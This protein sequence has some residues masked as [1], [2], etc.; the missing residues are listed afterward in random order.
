MIVAL[1]LYRSRSRH[2]AAR[3]VGGRTPGALAGPMAPLRLVNRPEPNPPQSGWARLRPRL[4]GICGSDLATLSGQSSLYLSPLVSTPFVPGHEVVGELLDDAGDVPAGTRVVLDPVLSCG[5]RGLSPCP[6]CAAGETSRCDHITVGDLAPGLQTGYC[7]DTGGGWAHTMLAHRDQVQPVP[8]AL[9][10]EQA[11]LAEPLA[12]AIHAARRARLSG[13]DHVL[14]VGAGTVGLL[15]LVALRALTAAT[16]ITVVAKHPRQRD[17][18][19]EL[20]ATTVVSPDR[21]ASAL[22]RATR[23]FMLRPER[24]QPLLLGGADVAFECTGARPG[25]DMATR[26]VAAGGQVVLAGMPTAGADLAPVWL[27]ELELTGAYASTGAD[28]FATALELVSTADLGGFVG[29]I[30][31]L[32]RWRQALDHAFGAGSLG[33]LKVAFDPQRE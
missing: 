13:G 30:Y 23:A 1:E 5:P 17:L 27:R 16:K 7:A 3:A 4:S 21:A 11:V 22:R 14:V 15:V 28:D 24:G 20:G 8:A 31:P 25:L 9:S 32:A 10:D 12:C 18:A 26:S 19:S 33:T 2:V 6:Q 29:G